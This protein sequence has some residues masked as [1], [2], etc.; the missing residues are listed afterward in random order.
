MAFSLSSLFLRTYTRFREHT[1]GSVRCSPQYLTKRFDLLIKSLTFS[2][3]IYLLHVM[4]LVRTRGRRHFGFCC[5]VLRLRCLCYWFP[6]MRLS[7]NATW[8]IFPFHKLLLEFTYMYFKK[9]TSNPMLYLQ[10]YIY[11]CLI[12]RYLCVWCTY[13]HIHAI[14]FLCVYVFV[15]WPFHC[16]GQA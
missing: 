2:L 9:S 16:L 4:T 8:L 10:S 1:N 12:Y 11:S 3:K 14:Y 7:P 15:Q 5:F 13:I 6:D